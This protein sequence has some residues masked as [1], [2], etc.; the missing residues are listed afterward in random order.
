MT[1][2]GAILRKIDQEKMDKLVC[3]AHRT[4]QKTEISSPES[5]LEKS[6]LANLK[7]LADSTDS[8]EALKLFIQYQMGR[9]G[10]NR[11]WKHNNFGGKV[12]DDI[13]ELKKMAHDIS[14]EAS[15]AVTLHLV[16][17]YTGFLVRWFVALRGQATSGS[18]E[19]E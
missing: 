19:T 12:L 18:A 3:M 7:N 14:T 8:V 4:V 16:R 2:S 10:G 1:V 17:L 11:G 13:E 9:E 15:K 6:Q 5:G